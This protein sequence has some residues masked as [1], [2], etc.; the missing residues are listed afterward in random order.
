MYNLGLGNLEFSVNHTVEVHRPEGVYIPGNLWDEM[1][2]TQ[3]TS[4]YHS[5]VFKKLHDTHQH[6]AVLLY[7]KSELITMHLQ[8]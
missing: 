7:P 2:N 8:L 6:E 5:I 1:N 3:I 4:E